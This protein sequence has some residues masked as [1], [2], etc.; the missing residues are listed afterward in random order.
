MRSLRILVSMLMA[1]AAFA[2]SDDIFHR[3]RTTL[4]ATGSAEAAATALGNHDFARVEQIL[5]DLKPAGQAERCEVLALEGAVEFMDGKMNAAAHEFQKASELG[6][7]SDAD[8]F[9]FAMALV[10]LNDEAHAR[11]LLSA[12]HEK[13]PKQAIY[14]YWLGRIDYSERRYD[15]AVE[16][17]RRA[18]ELDPESARIWDSLGLALDM[19]G[20]MDQAREA[21]QKGADL[22]RAQAHPSPW[23][24]H[25]LG[26]LLL[27][28][29]QLKEAEKSLRESLRYDPHLA[30][31]HYHLGRV[32]EKEAR[33]AEA[34]EEYRSAISADPA[35]SN[36]YYSLALLYRKLH[37]KSEAA[38]MFAE[39]EK[40]KARVN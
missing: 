35:S 4:S 8:S 14:I 26:F 16:K 23:P 15:E 37:R 11:P 30:Q 38:A 33:A 27:R 28:M 20:R 25:D 7:L 40:R 5:A 18:S 6:P 17:L 39:Y 21:F 2:Q 34:I 3:L 19:Q 1:V 12:L 29:D 10:N 31:A 24:P 36:S 32:L 13:Y 22:N 9:T